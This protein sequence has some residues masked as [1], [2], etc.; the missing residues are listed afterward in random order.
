M[1][2]R[3]SGTFKKDVREYNGL[4]HI[5][6]QLIDSPLDRHV[7]VL[8][9]ETKKIVRDIADGGTEE[10][11]VQVVHIEPLEGDDAEAA[12][13]LLDA[14][15]RKRTNRAEAPPDTIPFGD[16]PTSERPAD[17]WLDETGTTSAKR[18]KK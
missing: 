15:Y 1:T 17:E 5:I 6:K 4:E 9:V 2:V 12:A 8:K 7:C 10:P 18:G 3:I 11:T 16:A 13:K 14:A